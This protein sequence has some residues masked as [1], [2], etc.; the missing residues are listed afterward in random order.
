MS[1]HLEGLQ[2]SLRSLP[3]GLARGP[4]LGA[5]APGMTPPPGEPAPWAARPAGTTRYCS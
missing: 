3:P 5:D 1:D 4:G 2:Q